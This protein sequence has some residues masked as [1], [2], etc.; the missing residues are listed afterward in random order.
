MKKILL[1]I[2]VAMG[3]AG[4][5]EAQSNAYVWEDKVNGFSF[6]FP[7]SWVMLTND[8]PST[9]IRISG[10][11]VEDVATCRVK[12]QKDGRLA[13][14][15]K[16]LMTIAVMETLDYDF[17]EQEVAGH[18]NAVIT[19]YFTPASLGGQGDAT[20]I[21]TS[22]VQDN[23][24]GKEE[25]FGQMIGSLYGD[26]RYIVSCSSR[27]GAFAQYAPLFASIMDSVALDSRYHPFTAGYYRN[28]LADYKAYIPVR[29]KPGSSPPM[30]RY[31]LQWW[32]PYVR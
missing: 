22:F 28:F 29:T 17:W 21:R 5:A 30:N 9:R 1:G 19:D 32:R 11:I 25:M 15:P 7:D 10:P 26:T 18:E 14:Y 20:A 4:A 6:S 24:N 31:V 16:R 23:G 3:I 27:A 13:I 8:L 12:S 2:V